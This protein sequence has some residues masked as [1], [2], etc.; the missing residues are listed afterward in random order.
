[1]TRSSADRLSGTMSTPPSARFGRGAVARGVAG[2]AAPAPGRRGS[3]PS[4]LPA[5]A[6][7]GHGGH[8]G[9][10]NRPA[11]WRQSPPP[12]PG[13]L[14]RRGPRALPMPPTT[15]MPLR[16]AGIP[17]RPAR[18]SPAAGVGRPPPPRPA[19]GAGRSRRT[20]VPSG[21]RMGAA[22]SWQPL[23]AGSA[24]ITASCGMLTVTGVGRRRVARLMR[25]TGA[26][27]AAPAAR[28]SGSP[29]SRSARIRA[30]EIAG[31]ANNPRARLARTR[32]LSGATRR[33]RRAAASASSR[34]PRSE[35]A[36]MT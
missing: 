12:L 7:W 15:P 26:I 8:R 34:R 2:P 24:A 33:N 14:R 19:C 10:R 16:P 30:F 1:M 35:S 17:R 20:R 9:R 6:A 36:T 22:R 28:H 27:G 31:S 18:R 25:G 4:A 3:R 23:P 32:A 29:A 21:P 11:P 5:A 13:D